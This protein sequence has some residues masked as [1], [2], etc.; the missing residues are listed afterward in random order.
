[1]LDINEIGLMLS[2]ML[3]MKAGQIGKV[4]LFSKA[5]FPRQQHQLYTKC[6]THSREFSFKGRGDLISPLYW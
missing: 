2:T 5:I 4:R 3:T 1:M 6:S